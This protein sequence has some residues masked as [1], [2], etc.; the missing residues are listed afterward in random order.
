M[1]LS[2]AL[3]LDNKLLKYI[4]GSACNPVIVPVFKTGGRHLAMSP[5]GSDPNPLP[6]IV[7]NE[8]HDFVQRPD[9]AWRRRA[10]LRLNDE[11]D[12]KRWRL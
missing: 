11:K 1:D 5:V 2:L 12:I 10:R 4:D 8:L 3:C 6:P 7:F 9:H